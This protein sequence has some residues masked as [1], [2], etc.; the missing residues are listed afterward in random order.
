[1]IRPVLE[2]AI[3]IGKPGAQ[4]ELF[5]DAP[6]L[7][8]GLT[9]SRGFPMCEVCGTRESIGPHQERRLDLCTRCWSPVLDPIGAASWDRIEAA[10]QP[11]ETV[12]LACALL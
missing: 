4:L 7:Q 6:A 12:R 11:V 2:G 1:M 9:G 10:R 8:R 5:A 3:R